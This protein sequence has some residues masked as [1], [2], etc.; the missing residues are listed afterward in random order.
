MVPLCTVYTSGTA[1]VLG[2]LLSKL[3]YTFLPLPF[4][5]ENNKQR[6]AP[7]SSHREEQRFHNMIIIPY[8]TIVHLALSTDRFDSITTASKSSCQ[9]LQQMELDW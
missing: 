1:V 3:S 9:H 8:H 4:L 7:G 6:L 5:F 2:C